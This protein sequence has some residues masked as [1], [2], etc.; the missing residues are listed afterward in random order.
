MTLEERIASLE[1]GNRQ[2]RAAL[3]ACAAALA[4]T[5]GLACF[6]RPGGQVLRVRGLV[7]EDEA[8]RPRVLIGAPIPE[9]GGR[10]RTDRTT[11]LFILGPNGS[12]RVALAYPG[13]PPQVLGKVAQRGTSDGAGIMLNDVEGNERGGFG[14]GDDN[15]VSLGLD[16]AD[17]DAVGLLVSPKTGFAGLAAF[18][19]AGEREDQVVIGVTRKGSAMLKLADSHGNEKLIVEVGN[20]N[21][22]RVQMSDPKTGKLQEMVPRLLR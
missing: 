10:R 6:G 2:L 19:A 7:V 5:W 13:L 20:A 15:S 14:V 3:L 18:A 4:L 21:A 22:A 1:S 9:V 16:Y 17:R 11:G 12:D 8:G